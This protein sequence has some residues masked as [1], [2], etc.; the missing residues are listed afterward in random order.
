MNQGVDKP[1]A[2]LFQPQFHGIQG[3]HPDR[4]AESH[5][6]KVQPRDCNDNRDFDKKMCM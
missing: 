2:A 1:A 4:K 5:L 6:D 3:Y